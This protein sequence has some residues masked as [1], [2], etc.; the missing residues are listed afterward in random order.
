MPTQLISEQEQR[1]YTKLPYN[2][3]LEVIREM[4]DKIAPV[5][6]LTFEECYDK[7]VAKV[8]GYHN[9][10]SYSVPVVR[11][12]GRLFTLVIGYNFYHWTVS[13]DG[14][15]F[16]FDEK[17][18]DGLLINGTNYTGHPDISY[19]MPV[20]FVFKNLSPSNTSKFTVEIIDKLR[21][22]TF[23]WLLQK[24]VASSR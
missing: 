11:I 9:S 4:V 10:K 24:Q 17:L 15:S 16:T 13:Y 1:S 5:L 2:E 20:E 3:H 19:I 21:L 7:H 8:I 6:G 18:L 22:F 12:P 23:I 14:P